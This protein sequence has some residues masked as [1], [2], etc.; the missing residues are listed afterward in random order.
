MASSSIF[1]P[2][3]CWRTMLQ[4]TVS[5]SRNKN[6]GTTLQ[7]VTC[8]LPWSGADVRVWIYGRER[9]VPRVPSA[10]SLY[11]AQLLGELGQGLL[12]PAWHA[13]SKTA[14]RTS[15]SPHCASTAAQEANGAR[16]RKQPRDGRRDRPSCWPLGAAEVT[17]GRLQGRHCARAPGA[18]PAALAQAGSH[19]GAGRYPRLGAWLLTSGE[20]LLRG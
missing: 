20:P 12:A 15:D 8:P 10:P 4:L 14:P 7:M 19:R 11:D 13:S 1:Q 9:D 3:E 5:V 17:P 18:A 2:G 16:Q 6:R